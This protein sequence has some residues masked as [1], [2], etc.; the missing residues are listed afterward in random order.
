MFSLVLSMFLMV[1]VVKCDISGCPGGM[2]ISFQ[3]SKRDLIS[4]SI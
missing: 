2:P 1:T 3:Y 4:V